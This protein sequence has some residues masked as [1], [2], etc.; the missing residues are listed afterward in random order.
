MVYQYKINGIYKTPAQVAGEVCAQLENSPTGLTP[1]SLLDASRDKNAPLHDEFEWNDTIAAERYREKQAG[2]II[3]NICIVR[4]ESFEQEPTRAFVNIRSTEKPGVFHNIT[5]VMDDS[6]MREKLMSSAKREMQS[7]IA[8]YKTLEALSG[9]IA[10][11]ML[12][13]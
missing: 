12:V 5:A 9:V 4:A 7:F 6:V 11:M 10:E 1:K 8:K 13:S 3:R 2:D